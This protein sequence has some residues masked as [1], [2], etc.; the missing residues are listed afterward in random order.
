[1]HFEE[2]VHAFASAEKTNSFIRCKRYV[3]RTHYINDAFKQSLYEVRRNLW[4]ILCL[5]YLHWEYWQIYLL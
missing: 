1:M 3:Y 4:Y 5:L 2:P